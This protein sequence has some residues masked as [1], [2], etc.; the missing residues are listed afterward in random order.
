MKSILL[1]LVSALLTG[2]SFAQM[3]K[4]PNGIYLTLEQ[5][6]NQTPAF[7]A[8]LKIILRTS[9]DIFMSGGNDYKLESEIDTIDK[10]YIKQKIY[11]YVKNDSVLI[12]CF[13]HKLQIWYA[14]TITSGNFL[15]FKACMTNSDAMTVGILTGAIGA[16]VT[17]GKRYLNV[18]SL[19]TGNV[20]ELTKTYMIKRLEEQPDLLQQYNKEVAPD[21][22][23]TLI[24][25]VNLLNVV[26]AP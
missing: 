2:L 10:K 1:T 24:R 8:D 13:Q 20:R 3:N 16:G 12:N 9:G 17:A 4:F 18:L 5:L 6:R 15:A 23:A 21:S 11:A 25:Y 14:L 22:E 7:N 19:R 26:T